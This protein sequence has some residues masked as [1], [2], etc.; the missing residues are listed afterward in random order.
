MTKD[1]DTG[2][3]IVAGG[4]RGF[5]RSLHHRSVIRVAAAFDARW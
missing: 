2:D 5:L 4:V 1:M 3:R